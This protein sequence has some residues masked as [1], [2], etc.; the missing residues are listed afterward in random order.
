MIAC[1]SVLLFAASLFA[2]FASPPDTGF[3]QNASPVPPARKIP[4][5]IYPRAVQAVV[6]IST[7]E[8]QTAG[9]GIVIG[10]TRNGLP[11]ILTANALINGH[12]D[13]ITIQAAEQG[14][15]A[16]G[17][18]ISGK[19]RNRDLVLLAARKPLPVAAALPYGQ[20]D[21]LMP[22]ENA[23]VLGFSQSKFLEQNAG[24]IVRNEAHQLMLN[25][26]MSEGQTGG[27][28]LDQNGRIIGI[29]VSRP[30]ELSQ[31]IPIDLARI[32]LEQ[33]LGK[34]QLMEAWQE[35]KSTNHWQGWVVAAALLLVTGVAVGV[36]GV[37]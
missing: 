18:L 36:S 7:G 9:A 1:R 5:A 15:A 24:Q 3:G 28:V 25:L 31:A 12:E 23:A 21:Q 33:W 2:S 8:N 14:Q 11:V 37:F 26:V 22:G 30:Q 34:T 13:K 20:S 27:P 16:P 32:T 19:W 17:R 6:K 29:A 10:K 35:G 4:E